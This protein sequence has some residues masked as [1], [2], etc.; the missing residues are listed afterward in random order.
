M[1]TSILTCIAFN[2][3]SLFR[4]VHLRS[5]ENRRAKWL[6]VLLWL[7]FAFYLPAAALRAVAALEQAE[8]E[9]PLPA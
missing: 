9:C 2:L 7:V 4:G 6:R 1:N 8:Q 3:L 5:E